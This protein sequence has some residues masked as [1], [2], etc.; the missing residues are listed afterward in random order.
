M[1]HTTF[2]AIRAAQPDGRWK[3]PLA[4]PGLSTVPWRG[5]VG[6]AFDYRVRW[7]W[8]WVPSTDLVALHLASL[9][10]GRASAQALADHT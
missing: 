7:Y 4:A 9:L 5:R 2:T 1:V 3:Q 6:T 8:P 10:L